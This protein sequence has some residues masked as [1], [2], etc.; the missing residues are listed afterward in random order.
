MGD[1]MQKTKNIGDLRKV[2]KWEKTYVDRGSMQAHNKLTQKK[3][4]G[5]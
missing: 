3:K 5:N 2:D 1:R 4:K